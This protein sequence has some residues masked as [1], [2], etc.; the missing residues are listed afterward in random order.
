MRTPNFGLSRW[1]YP[2]QTTVAVIMAFLPGT[3][4]LYYYKKVNWSLLGGTLQFVTMIT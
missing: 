4:C 1:L 3:S 2:K